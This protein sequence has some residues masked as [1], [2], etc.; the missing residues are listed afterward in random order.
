MKLCG[1]CLEAAED[2]SVTA[3][4]HTFHSE[5]LDKWT[6]RSNTCPLC[7]ASLA[8]TSSVFHEVDVGGGPPLL[9]VIGHVLEAGGGR[10][11]GWL[12]EPLSERRAMLRRCLNRFMIAVL[13]GFLYHVAAV[14]IG[15]YF[16]VFVRS[17]QR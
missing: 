7:R 16:G 9:F 2:G 11:G 15:M 3:C 4:G 13:Y 17:S 5:C 12:G 6:Q 14:G 10:E 8:A 1:I